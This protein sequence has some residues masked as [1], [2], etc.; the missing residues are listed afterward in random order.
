[1]PTTVLEVYICMRYLCY[2]HIIANSM[3]QMDMTHQV[4][5]EEE[6]PGQSEVKG[7][8]FVP[9]LGLS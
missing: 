8:E 9:A 4:G 7:V 2:I 6:Q 1:M 5:R 3:A